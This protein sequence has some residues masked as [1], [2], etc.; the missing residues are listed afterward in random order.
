MKKIAVLLLMILSFN[1]P[2]QTTKITKLKPTVER[3]TIHSYNIASVVDDREDTTIIGTMR[4]GLTNK[5][6]FVNLPNGARA[7]ISSFLDES[8]WQSPATDSI[9]LHIQELVIS[10]KASTFKERATLNT[11]YG[12]FKNGT[13]IIEYSGNA[14]VESGTDVSPFIGKLVSES[15]EKV[16]KEFD[17][18]WPD[19][20]HL[21][22]DS[23]RD[24]LRVNVKLQTA[25]NSADEIIYSTARPL[26]L[27]DFKGKPD[28][29][30][31]ALA[32]TYSGFS[33]QYEMQGDHTGALATIQ[34]KPYFLTSK[35][36]M[37]KEGKVPYVLQHEQLHFDIATLKA[38]ELIIELRS[39]SFKVSD[40]KDQIN[41]LQQKYSSEM[42][43]MQADYDS[44]TS[45]GIFKEKQNL[46]QVRIQKELQQKLA[47]AAS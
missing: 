2:A 24:E 20:K 15:V 8:L 12:F 39:M 28:E 3:L 36:W 34:I 44:E 6:A 38:C 13:K 25:G 35:S 26:T 17:T 27:E 16:L 9:T 43:K 41:A 30:S 47:E 45:H 23:K 18:W 31:K 40:F 4:A 14:Y 22:D 1:L 7:A 32:A 42:E 21:F 33:L 5:K 46:W 19:N 11:R 37:R 29:L 10:E